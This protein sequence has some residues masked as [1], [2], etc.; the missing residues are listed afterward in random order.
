[1]NE[2]AEH[3]RVVASSRAKNP[4]V[5]C[6]TRKR[7]CG[8]NCQICQ[9][10][11]KRRKYYFLSSFASKLFFCFDDRDGDAMA[12]FQAFNN[13]VFLTHLTWIIQLRS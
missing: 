1:M 7:L 5:V 11:R 4:K 12:F 10:S 6:S 3:R 2:R 13:D 8:L 9:E